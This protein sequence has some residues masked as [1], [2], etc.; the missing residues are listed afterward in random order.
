MDSLR[1]KLRQKHRGLSQIEIVASTL[2][3]GVMLV[4]ALNT[5]GA[6]FRSQRSNA[7]RMTGPGL[8][9]EL[10]GEILSLP[11]EDPEEPGEQIGPDSG[12]LVSDRA[13]FDDVDDY[14]DW[15]KQ[16]LEN[17]DGVEHPDYVGWE[18]DVQVNWVQLNAVTMTLSSESGLKLITVT[19]T[20]P[21]DMDTQI[22]ALRSRDSSFEQSPAV[23]MT[24]VT[25]LGAELQLRGSAAAHSATQLSNQTYDTN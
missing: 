10:M 11:Y 16:K 20:D 1:Q 13:D 4:A 3:V 15:N 17:K 22:C 5:L 6:V 21:D 24:A 7:A 8:A 25:W 18:A 23:D 2:I 12:E 9:H 14:R 19:V